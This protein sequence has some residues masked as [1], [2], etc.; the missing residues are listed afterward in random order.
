MIRSGEFFSRQIMSISGHKK[1]TT[2]LKYIRLSLYE[3]A[4]DVAKVASDGLFLRI[5]KGK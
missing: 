1:E 3:K 2:F 4:D 5:E